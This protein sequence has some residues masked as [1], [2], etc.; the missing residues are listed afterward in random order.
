MHLTP[1]KTCFGTSQKYCFK[2]AIKI[3]IIKKILVRTKKYCFY[4][5]TC[6]IRDSHVYTAQRQNEPKRTR[7]YETNTGAFFKHH[8][9]S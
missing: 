1:L 8:K 6:S 9:K 4:N 3:D 2:I 7:H 5:S